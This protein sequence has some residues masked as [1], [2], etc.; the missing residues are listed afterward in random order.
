MKIVAICRVSTTK[1]EIQ[2][3]ID[4]LKSFILNDGVVEDDIIWVTG[5][6]VSA[7]KEDDKFKA[8]IENVLTYIKMVA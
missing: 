3:Q 5:V 4:E 8:N 1:Q 7:V 2:S 6:G